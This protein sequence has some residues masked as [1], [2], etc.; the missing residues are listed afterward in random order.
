MYKNNHTLVSKYILNKHTH[1]ILIVFFL[2]YEQ[3]QQTSFYLLT[4]HI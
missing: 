3:I 4:N 2:N 1:Q